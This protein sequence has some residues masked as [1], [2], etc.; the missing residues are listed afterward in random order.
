MNE[1]DLE[2]AAKMTLAKV[3][4]VQTKVDKWVRELRAAEAE[5]HKAQVALQRARRKRLVA[6][7]TYVS[8]ILRRLKSITRNGCR[9]DALWDA[10]F[11]LLSEEQQKQFRDANG[12]ISRLFGGSDMT[13]REVHRSQA[14]VFLSLLKPCRKRQLETA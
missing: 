11:E 4:R 14:A 12:E 2:T 10:A 8:D 6:D 7:T 1:A 13:L 5:G 3:R 9:F